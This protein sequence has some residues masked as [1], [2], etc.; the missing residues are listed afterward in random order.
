MMNHQVNTPGVENKP[1]AS[2]EYTAKTYTRWQQFR[3]G[4]KLFVIGGIVLL[5]FGL[6]EKLHLYY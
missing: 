2:G 3:S 6:V 1:P 4:I 5:L